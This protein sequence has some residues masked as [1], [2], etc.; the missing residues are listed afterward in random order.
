[1]KNK[2]FTGTI[3]MFDDLL[4]KYN[5]FPI[6]NVEG[7]NTE[8][9]EW[10]ISSTTYDILHVKYYSVISNFV[11]WTIKYYDPLK[12]VTKY[13]Y[14][15]V[16]MKKKFF[17]HIIMA[18][19]FIRN[20]YKSD[21]VKHKDGNKDNNSPSNLEWIIKSDYLSKYFVMKESSYKYTYK[22]LGINK[23]FKITYNTPKEDSYEDFKQTAV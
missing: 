3:N 1:M 17:L 2:S 23:P 15:Y 8:H 14:H 19:T 7:I 9:D 12:N 13:G 6:R 16:Y 10:F 4:L 18:S 11:S 20:I 22:D 5:F 21:K